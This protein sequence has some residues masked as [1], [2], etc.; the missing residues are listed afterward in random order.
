M[1][2]AS[3]IRYLEY[4]AALCRRKILRMIEAGGYGHLGGAFSCIDIISAIYFHTLNVDP[5]NP[6][7]PDR[8]RFI[9]SAG[10]KCM[11]QYAVLAQKGF[12]DESVLDTYAHLNTG[13]TGHPNMHKL[14]GLDTSTGALGHGL[15]MALGIALSLRLD[16]KKAKTFVLI[17]DGEL[18]EGSNWEAAAAASHYKVDNLIVFIDKNG[19]QA[20]G[21]TADIMNTSP[22]ER[23][24]AFGW[25]VREI[26]G[27]NIAQIVDVLDSVP[28]T[29]GKPSA[30]VAATVKGKGLSF[31]E[32]NP[33]YH[34]WNPA[35][36]ELKQ[37]IREIDRKIEE[38]KP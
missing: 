17:G 21:R 29:P 7:M 4:S 35:E 33:D 16:K 32:G 20:D 27:H 30:V 9:L 15:S 31:A 6:K 11:A 8:D 12:F 24:R 10:H 23:L 36:E 28:F 2:N 22:V 1:N 37:A 5:K 3:D 25:A 14:P 38:L 26:D 18:A 13:L 19:L 34:N